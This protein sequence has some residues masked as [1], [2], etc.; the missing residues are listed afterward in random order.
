[1]Q[2]PVYTQVGSSSSE[3]QFK[4]ECA[5]C[6]LRGSVWATGDGT[7]L[8]VYGV[9]VSQANLDARASATQAASLTAC[10]R[11][12]RR[13]RLALAKVMATSSLVGLP[14][15]IAVGTW[16]SERFNAFDPEGRLVVPSGILTLAATAAVF[17]WYKLRKIR[18]RVRFVSTEA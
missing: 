15:A 14:A 10:P 11:C 13:D 18:G 12:G 2:I 8:A 5:R 7:G 3:M 9:S 1:M 4:F 16:A 17:T 6:G